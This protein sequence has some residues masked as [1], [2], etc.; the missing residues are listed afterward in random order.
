MPYRPR[1]KPWSSRKMQRLPEDAPERQRAA[2]A[3]PASAPTARKSWE[4]AARKLVQRE[5]AEPKPRRRRRG[6]ARGTFRAAAA[7]TMRQVVE[8]AAVVR[9][10][11]FLSD[12]LDWLNL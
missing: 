6:D 5:P 3:A 7:M 1:Q 2:S 11:S 10:G 9:A 12:T 4:L 8:F